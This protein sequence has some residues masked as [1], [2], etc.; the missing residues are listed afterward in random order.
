MSGNVPTSE[1]VICEKNGENSTENADNKTTSNET[2]EFKKNDENNSTKDGESKTIAAKTK[3][4]KKSKKKVQQQS[5][6]PKVRI[7]AVFVPL[8]RK[9]EIQAARLKLPVV[10]EEQVIV[11]KIN[12]N[13]I[14]IITGETG[15]GR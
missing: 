14:V 4:S 13:P 3:E 8:N 2:Q 10:A 15:S 7:P 1:T 6:T 9:P 5:V 11:E 12:E